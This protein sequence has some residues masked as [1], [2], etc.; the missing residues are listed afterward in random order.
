M[1][2]TFIALGIAV[3]IILGF[4]WA[5][6]H[7]DNGATTA[8][9]NPP[10]SSDPSGGSSKA[11]LKDNSGKAAGSSEPFN[12]SSTQKGPS[13]KGTLIRHQPSQEKQKRPVA[14]NDLNILKGESNEGSA[15]EHS[16]EAQG[17]RKTP[18]ASGKLAKIEDLTSIYPQSQQDPSTESVA[19]DKKATVIAGVPIRSWV[20]SEQNSLTNVSVPEARD[21]GLKVYYWCMELKKQHFEYTGVNRCKSILES[22]HEERV[23][24]H[25]RGQPG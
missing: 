14:M 25:F 21:M 23:A 7:K 19:N 12:G 16:F 8:N 9:S 11:G 4:L 10:I 20:L 13:A 5:K 22:Q 18:R 17:T 6:G 15:S 1:R 3:M 2:N 24:A